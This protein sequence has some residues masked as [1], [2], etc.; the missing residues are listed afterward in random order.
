MKNNFEILDCTFRDGGYYNLWDFEDV[1]IDSYLDSV[2]NLPIDFIEIGYKNFQS[3]KYFGKFYYSPNHIIKEIRDRCNKKIAIMIDEKKYTAEDILSLLESCSKNIDL[4]R[5]A[6]D[7]ERIEYAHEKVLQLK[8]L[9]VPIAC[10]FMYLN[11]WNQIPNFYS[12]LKLISLEVEYIYLVDSFGSVY[13]NQLKSIIDKAKGEVKCKLGFH[14]H[15]NLELAFANTLVA[16]ASGINI[17]DSTVLGM[18]RGA[19]NLKT[20]LLL[21][22]ISNS[23]IIVNFNYLS[24]LVESFTDLH[25]KYKWGTNLPYMLSGI[26]ETPQKLIMD[27]ISKKVLNFNSIINKIINPTNT[28]LA[29][30]KF[31]KR[32]KDK[33]VII[34]G[35]T[36]I[37]T[38]LKAIIVFLKD[39]PKIDIIFSST[40]HFG[41]FNKLP[42]SKILCFIG[43]ESE[44]IDLREYDLDNNVISVIPPLSNEIIPTKIPD[45]FVDKTYEIEN[46]DIIKSQ[47]I[48]NC[49]I[50]LEL[51]KKISN[52]KV[53]LI[54]FDGYENSNDINEIQLFN[55]ND[56]LFKSIPNLE[57]RS[58][59]PTTYKNLIADSIYSYL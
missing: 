26:T 10:N 20:E 54:G 35:G 22:Y 32:N 45:F 50:S 8:K 52:K 15:N 37:E 46:M 59:T 53:F 24:N 33:C 28:R 13:P 34:G 9:G 44:R 16:I 40:R 7:P 5:L 39:N 58:L 23:G 19:G 56:H 17:I 3:Q 30:P 18:G 2:N 51:A 25:L 31:Q 55:E 27:W 4:I 11:K 29:F 1:L 38:H 36:S 43:D 49:C 12:S 21:S 41:L 42:N 6:I 48:T 14:G 57:L 47:I